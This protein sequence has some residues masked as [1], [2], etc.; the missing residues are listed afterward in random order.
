MDDVCKLDNILKSFVPD[1]K[2]QS[3]H[4]SLLAANPE[5][6]KSLVSLPFNFI[7]KVAVLKS[8][9]SSSTEVM[10]GTQTR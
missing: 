10:V 8:R 2:R 1:V 5:N 6:E 4:R 9:S 7:E 3:P